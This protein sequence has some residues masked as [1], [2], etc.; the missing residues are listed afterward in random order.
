M[1]L[2]SKKN[3]SERDREAKE[4]VTNVGKRIVFEDAFQGTRRL[5]GKLVENNVLFRLF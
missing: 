3:V 2:I 1:R 5:R 4:H